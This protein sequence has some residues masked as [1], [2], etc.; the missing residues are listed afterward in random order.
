[1]DHNILQTALRILNAYVAYQAPTEA[2][3][4]RLREAAEEGE[5]D[6]PADILATRIIERE[7][8]RQRMA[9]RA[10]APTTTKRIAEGTAGLID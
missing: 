6:L 9:P 2:D 7:I 4:A 8:Y 3:V 10:V 5:R 1:M